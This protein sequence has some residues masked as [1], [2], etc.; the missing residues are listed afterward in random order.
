[1]ARAPRETRETFIANVR[2][3]NCLL[4]PL[5]TSVCQSSAFPW[6]EPLCTFHFTFAHPAPAVHPQAYA[7]GAGTSALPGGAD[8]LHSLL[9]NGP[10]LPPSRGVL[11][12]TST[13]TARRRISASSSSASSSSHHPPPPPMRLL[14]AH[15]AS[16]LGLDE[17]AFC[18]RI[19]NHRSMLHS[20]QY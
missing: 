9:C 10:R 5:N 20:R 13:H 8:A 19:F 4:P 7:R 3:H 6:K 16:A 14:N 17:S 2:P 11:L 1:M 15:H 18:K 12:R